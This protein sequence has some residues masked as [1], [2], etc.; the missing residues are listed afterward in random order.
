MCPRIGDF[1]R[2]KKRIYFKKA[3]YYLLRYKKMGVFVILTAFLSS[4]FEGFGIG[5]IVP[6]LQGLVGAGETT[7]ENMPIP[8]VGGLIDGLNVSESATWIPWILV[9]LLFMVIMKDVFAYLNVIFV[10]KTSNFIKRDLQ[11][12]LFSA[13]VDAD[14]SFFHEIKAGHLVGGIAVYAENVAQFIFSFLSF[15]IVITR[16]CLFFVLLLVLSWKTTGMILFAGLIVLPLARIVLIQIRRVGFRVAKNVSDMHFRMNDMFQNIALIKIFGTE[17]IEKERFAQTSHDLAMNG[18]RGSQ[19]SNILAPFSEII[20]VLILVSLGIVLSQTGIGVSSGSLVI[21]VTYIYV[22]SR[23]YTEV[24]NFVRLLSGVFAYIE[25]FREYEMI[26][27][28]A[29]SKKRQQG[30]GIIKTFSK[31]ITFQDVSFSY[32]KEEPVLSNVHFSIQKGTFV[33]FVGPTGAGKSTLAN[34]IAGM[35]IPTSGSIHIDG[36]QSLDLHAWRTH[37]GYVSQDVLILHDTVA[38]NIRYGRQDATD[39]D[40][41][42]A[43]TMANIH[44]VIMALPN[45]YE[46]I[47]GDRGQTLS[48]GQRQRLSLARALIR[49][50]DILLLDEATSSLD[51]A[52][53]QDIQRIIFTQL[54]GTTV[55]AIAHRLSTIEHADKIIVLSE[56]RVQE[57]GTHAELIEKKGLYW[58]LQNINS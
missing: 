55:I 52:I 41:K 18:Y 16:L 57:E 5:T 20:V 2:T 24:N 36:M 34:L 42:E 14:L 50:P 22:F 43:A 37:I 26:L 54:K 13:I 21:V 12:D 51:V 17:K 7:S 27:A 40:I 39:A 29:R 3:W 53:E 33:A 11:N 45:G 58:H 49:K 31:D 1:M 15:F 10:N 56:G 8:F 28:T 9:F 48:G 35:Y 46:T 6:L 44:D 23:L 32:R 30:E 19:F 47:L 38:N 25:P 4:F